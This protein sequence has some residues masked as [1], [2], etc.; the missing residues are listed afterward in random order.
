MRLKKLCISAAGAVAIIAVTASVGYAVWSASGSGSGGAAAT[1]A[2]G[3]TLTAA[4]PTG[5]QA[6]L[7][8]GGPAGT[9]EATVANPNPYGITITHVTW[10]TPISLNTSNCPS[11][12]LSVDTNAP[13]TVSIAV[14]ANAT[15]TTIAI[16]G[17]LDMSHA[18]PDGCQGIAVTVPMTI[19]GTEQ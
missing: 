11:A 14:P 6:N 13:T 4:T 5:A 18:A 16:P 7:Y 17:V 9:V 12:N 10:G 2:S 8:P 19:S 1:V 15:A 3:V